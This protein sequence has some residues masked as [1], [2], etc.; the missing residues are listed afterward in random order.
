V[1]RA[2]VARSVVTGNFLAAHVSVREHR[3]SAST[4]LQS[5]PAARPQ[6]NSAG[7]WLLACRR[8]IRLLPKPLTCR[9]RAVHL[10]P[11]RNH[12]LRIRVS[13]KIRLS[14]IYKIVFSVWK[15]SFPAHCSLKARLVPIPASLKPRL[16]A[17]FVTGFKKPNNSY[18][19][20]LSPV[21]QSMDGPYCPRFLICVSP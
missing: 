8:D 17:T 4:A 18:L 3:C 5:L 12:S 1:T 16:C 10:H 7:S 11:H 15:N 6:I 19:M 20:H 13:I 21:L 9:R 14:R 2:V